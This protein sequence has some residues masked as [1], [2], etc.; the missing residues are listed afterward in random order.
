VKPG[1]K[2]IATRERDPWAWAL[3][4][5]VAI[6]ALLLIGSQAI[7]VA[8][9][10][11]RDLGAGRVSPIWDLA[12]Y[13]RVL[14]DPFTWQC[15][16]LTAK[17][18]A[19]ATI[20]TIA[21]G[22]PAGYVLA[23]SRGRWVMPLLAGIVASTFVSIVVKVFGLM[24]L[25]TG[26]GPINRMLMATGLTAQP[27]TL[28]GSELGVVIG[29]MQF[30]LGFAVLLLFGMV[31]TIPPTLEEAAAAHGAKPTATFFR[32]VWPLALPG[33]AAVGLTVFN[34]CMGAFASAALLGSGRILTLPVLIERSIV[35]EV[36]TGLGA[37]LA[38]VLVAVVLTF[39]LLAIAGLRR[40]RGG[41]GVM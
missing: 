10:L 5:P 3:L 22:F 24:V 23:R 9:S 40:L 21:I 6:C 12:N 4:P 27:I 1:N 14:T 32:V 39:N 26:N 25:F 15:L 16:A 20:G 19:W 35:M 2:V 34:L 37:T 29:L 38:V 33:V 28:L 17:L 31:Q 7:F 41:R 11:H 36:R 30:T 13:R 8:G 18:S